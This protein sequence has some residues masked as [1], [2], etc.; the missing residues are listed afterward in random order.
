MCLLRGL[1]TAPCAGNI[2]PATYAHKEPLTQATPFL[3]SAEEPQA[4][5]NWLPGGPTPAVSM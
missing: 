4:G 2:W 3:G 1:P 5:N